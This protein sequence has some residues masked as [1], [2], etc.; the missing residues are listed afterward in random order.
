MD[1]IARVLRL[2]VAERDYLVNLARPARHTPSEPPQVRPGI[3]RMIEH[4]DGQAAFVLGPRMEVLTGNPAMW[5]LLTDFPAREADD[6]NLLRWVLTEPAARE[7]YVE[8]GQI[9]SDLVG[10]LQLEASARPRDPDIA[11]LVQELV[12]ASPEFRS[13]WS[14]PRPQGR[15]AGVKHFRHPVLGSLTIDW[16]AFSVTDDNTQTL[17]IYTAG[18]EESEAKL[19]QLATA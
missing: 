8:W 4:L 13:L 17:F 19:R 5:G 18:D 3:V 10:V 14:Q 7:L 9:A 16:E 1:A 6:R 12:A 15:T 2:D 11:A